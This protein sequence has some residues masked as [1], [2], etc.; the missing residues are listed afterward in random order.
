MS[1]F[2]GFGTALLIIYM[3]FHLA[4]TMFAVPNNPDNFLP[5][6][7]WALGPSNGDYTQFFQMLEKIPIHSG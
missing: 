3:I 7:N 1:T 5:I 4:N 6:T 2:S